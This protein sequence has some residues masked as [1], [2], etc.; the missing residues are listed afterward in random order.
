MTTETTAPT[1]HPINAQA[2]CAK[3][4]VELIRM[5]GDLPGVYV[6]IHSQITSIPA[7]LDLQA[8]SPADFEQWRTALAIAPNDVTLKAFNESVWLAAD[9]VFHGVHVHLDG[10]GIAL[11]A[12]LADTPQADDAAPAVAA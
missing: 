2:D 7:Q 1:G 6:K 3:A 11:A 12:E 5:F 10:F 4:L 8:G 9:G